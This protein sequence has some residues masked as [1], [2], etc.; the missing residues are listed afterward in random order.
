M[1]LVCFRQFQNVYNIKHTCR[2][3]Y[4]Y[5][6]FFT[7]GFHATQKFPKSWHVSTV[8]WL[9]IKFLSI[10]TFLICI[11]NWVHASIILVLHLAEALLYLY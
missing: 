10:L 1:A 8:E 9:L 5:D 2:I 7:S 11:P 6:L 4:F 3:V